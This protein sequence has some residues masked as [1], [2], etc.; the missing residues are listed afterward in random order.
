[1]RRS[2][3]VSGFARAEFLRCWGREQRC[4]LYSGFN[5]VECYLYS[6]LVIV[7]GGVKV[8]IEPEDVN[9]NP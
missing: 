3:G 9:P 2:V 8:A 7:A 6:G 1:M 5:G 4:S